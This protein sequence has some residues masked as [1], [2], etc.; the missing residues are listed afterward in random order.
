MAQ[1][2]GGF[3]GMPGSGIRRWRRPALFSS[4]YGATNLG[5][6]LTLVVG[7]LLGYALVKVIKVEQRFYSMRSAVV[8]ETSEARD[9]TDERIILNLQEEARELGLPRQAQGIYLVRGRDS[10][11]VSTRWTDTI[12]FWK[13]DWVRK[14]VV[15]SK[16]RIW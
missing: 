15:E 16:V 12:S 3:W 9:Q 13:I 14:R 11:Q 1:C 2:S 4:S 10:I 5:C 6:L 8:Q 7:A